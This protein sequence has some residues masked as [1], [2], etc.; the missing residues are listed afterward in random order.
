MPCPGGYN[1]LRNYLCANRGCRFWPYHSLTAAGGTTGTPSTRMWNTTPQRLRHCKPSPEINAVNAGTVADIVRQSLESGTPLKNADFGRYT[2]IKEQVADFVERRCAHRLGQ[3]DLN[4][5]SE[6]V[7]NFYAETMDKLAG[8]GASIVR[9]DAFAYLHK[10]IGQ[11]N[12]FNEPGTWDCLERLRQMA[13]ERKLVLLPE[14]HSKYEDGLHRKLT[15]RGYP[16]YDFFLPALLIHAI[17][18]G[19]A[20]KLTEWIMEVRDRN[21]QT[22]T[23]LGC[24]DGIPVLDVKGLLDDDD[25]EKP[26]RPDCQPGRPG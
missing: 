14:I 2:A 6:A 1:T 23:M 20:K 16:F 3:I 12:F 4:A 15:E 21:Y 7:W 19:S 8:Y 26:D 25:I 17:E 18:T 22:V 10:E 5:R 9:L 13:E 24:H 11:S